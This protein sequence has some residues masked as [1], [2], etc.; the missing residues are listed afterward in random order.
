MK[1][2]VALCQRLEMTAKIKT[3]AASSRRSPRRSAQYRQIW[4][5]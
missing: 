5:K 1:T 3:K 2:K 4:P